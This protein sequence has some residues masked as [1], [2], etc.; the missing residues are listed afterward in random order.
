MKRNNGI[1]LIALVIT[2]IVLIILAGVTLNL[3]LGQNGIFKKAEDAKRKNNESS[4]REKVEIVLMEAQTEKATNLNYNKEAFLNDMLE[5]SGITVEDDI[6]ILDNYSFLIDRE[7]LE[8]VESLGE[9][10]IKLNTQVQSYL[11]ANENGKYEVSVLLSIESNT[12][13]QSVVITNPDGTTSEVVPEG[14]IASKTLEIELDGIY[15]ITA[16]TADGKTG[17]RKLTEK[18]VE[19]IRTVEELVAFRDKVNTGLT[20]E[21]KTINVINDLDLSSVCG[22]TIGTWEPIGTFAG[23]FDGKYHIID[24]LYINNK[25][26][27]NAGLFISNTGT[28]KNI[29][30]KNVNIYINYTNS[31]TAASTNNIIGGI[32]A[33]NS[34]TIS[35][36]GVENGSIT[37]INTKASNVNYRSQQVGGIVGNNTGKIHNCYNKS[38]ISVTNTTSYSNSGTIRQP[39]NM[40]GGI[41]GFSYNNTEVINCYNSGKVAGYNSANNLVGGIVGRGYSVRIQNSYNIQ[42]T[43]GTCS[44]SSN[45]KV[46]GVLGEGYLPGGTP[47]ISNSYCSSLNTYSYTLLKTQ[48]SKT[49]YNTGV[50]SQTNLQGYAST[51]GDAFTND[52]KIKVINAETGLEEEV[53]KYND[54]YPILKWQIGE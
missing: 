20:Y 14:T 23:T 2:I 4:A 36:C 25:D 3:T 19:N 33:A 45:N 5:E 29:L 11:G 47:T 6:V 38:N 39:H 17:T 28:I 49:N 10:L 8:I 31:S 27:N 37:N 30:L 48:E 26:Y 12:D 46:N 53:W 34:G 44:Y 41:A 16:T 24:N 7:K 40:V 32:V 9:T 54:G 52:V 22:A 18:S 42:K 50:I 35:N 21:G 13:L 1:T 51:L 43:S 15:T